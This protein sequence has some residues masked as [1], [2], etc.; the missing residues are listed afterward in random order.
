[1]TYLTYL[2]SSRDPALYTVALEAGTASSKIES[3]TT[4]ASR[5]ISNTLGKK[6]VRNNNNNHDA[7]PCLKKVKSSTTTRLANPLQQLI[8]QSVPAQYLPIL[9]EQLEQRDHTDL[10][11]FIL[12]DEECNA[13]DSRVTLLGKLQN[14]PQFDSSIFVK[15]SK[16]PLEVQEKIRTSNQHLMEWIFS[17]RSEVSTSF[18][19]DENDCE[20]SYQEGELNARKKWV[21]D[22]F[23]TFFARSLGQRQLLKDGLI[24]EEKAVVDEYLKAIRGV[25]LT[26]MCVEIYA[27][28]RP[29]FYPI[30]P[31]EKLKPAWQA[32]ENYYRNNI[33]DLDK[34]TASSRIYDEPSS[35]IAPVL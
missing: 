16:L 3:P 33:A 10:M 28:I 32:I 29:R 22:Q 23:Q 27:N 7:A 18:P 14:R 8:E 17:R 25:F 26:I 2:K 6:R 35:V 11:G 5:E 21:N 9:K 19:I 20:R 34:Q 12:A 1:M 31:R 24:P 15:W 30:T 13:H 4:K